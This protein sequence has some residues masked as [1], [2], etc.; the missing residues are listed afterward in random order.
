M[1][2]LEKLIHGQ[3]VENKHIRQL[4]ARFHKTSGHTHDGTEDEGPILIT[5]LQTPLTST[6]WDGDSFSTTA[7]TLID[8]SAVFSVPAGVKAVLLNVVINDSGSAAATDCYIGFAP[9]NAAS[10]QACQVDCNGVPNDGFRRGG[11]WCPCDANGDIYYQI[12][13]T[14]AGTMDVRIRIWGYMI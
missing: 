8:L 1:P 10:P 7:A 11:G 3:L 6:S 4:Q 9:T 13:A 2:F 12:A 5:W 14:G